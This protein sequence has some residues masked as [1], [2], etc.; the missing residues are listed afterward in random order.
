MNYYSKVLRPSWSS[1]LIYKF[2][3]DTTDLDF[4]NTDY[5]IAF[6][7]YYYDSLI[8]HFKPIFYLIGYKIKPEI[9][10]FVIIYLN[11]VQNVEKFNKYSSQKIEIS[12]QID[13]NT[14]SVFTTLSNLEF[15]TLF[16]KFAGN[17]QKIKIDSISINCQYL[18]D[19]YEFY[20]SIKLFDFEIGKR[21]K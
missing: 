21:W 18:P 10:G 3:F 20:N 8:N 7:R 15:R 6:P 13:E 12:N 11:S 9:K 1:P 2:A 16:P 14:D 19:D 5:E 4:Q 17:Y